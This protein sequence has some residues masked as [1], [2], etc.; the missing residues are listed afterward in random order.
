MV[1]TQNPLC[2]YFTRMYLFV[3]GI[4]YLE[5]Y[6]RGLLRVT[7]SIK[8]FAMI[9]LHRDLKAVEGLSEDLIARLSIYH[10]STTRI[11]L[12]ARLSPHDS[13]YRMK[14]GPDPVRVTVP[15]VHSHP[16]SD[17]FSQG[18]NIN[19]RVHIRN[20]ISHEIPGCSNTW[21]HHRSKQQSDRERA[22]LPSHISHPRIT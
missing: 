21:P 7:H 16:A 9:S 2:C 10:K 15:H 19:Y 14:R 8:I 1:F 4:E 11:D 22:R 18:P 5:E 13:Q 20:L 17:T 12:R 3:K 6:H